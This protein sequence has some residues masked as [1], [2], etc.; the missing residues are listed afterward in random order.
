MIK[1]A[2]FK[3]ENDNSSSSQ[4]FRSEIG[5]NALDQPGLNKTEI[6]VNFLF[7]IFR[8]KFKSIFLPFIHPF[9]SSLFFYNQIGWYYRYR[10]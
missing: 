4:N 3:I 9:F 2:E 7:K 10:Y 5:F 1:R 6:R 8:Y